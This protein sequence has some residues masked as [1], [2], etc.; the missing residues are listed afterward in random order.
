M[1]GGSFIGIQNLNSRTES[2]SESLEVFASVSANFAFFDVDGSNDFKN[3]VSSSSSS[4][5]YKTS[6]KARG[7]GNLPPSSDD[8]IQMTNLYET[9]NSAVA[10]KPAGLKFVWRNWYDLTDVARTVD[11]IRNKTVRDMFTQKAPSTNT[12]NAVT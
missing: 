3:K 6:V 8:P 11:Q 7:G 12:F 2:S 5:K 4:L 10:D 1:Y 9:W